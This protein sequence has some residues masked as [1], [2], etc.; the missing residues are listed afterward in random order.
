[1]KNEKYF[2]KNIKCAKCN[3]EYNRSVLEEL[4]GEDY[5]RVEVFQGTS[6][7]AERYEVRDFPD[8][9]DLFILNCPNCERETVVGIQDS[10]IKT[11]VIESIKESDKEKFELA[12]GLA[13]RLAMNNTY[14]K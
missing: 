7:K 11:L 10:Y 13:I 12:E 5:F 1:M 3:V 8:P 9:V 4:Y 2:L 6:Y 14:I